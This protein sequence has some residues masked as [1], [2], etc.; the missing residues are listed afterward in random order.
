MSHDLVL[1]D[2]PPLAWRRRPAAL[3]AVAAARLLATRSPHRITRVLTRVRTGATPA[4]ADQTLAARN[5]VVA[6]SRHCA[7]DSSCL[8]RSLATALLCR[9]RG[10]WPTWHTGVRTRP[11]GAHAWVEA[12]GAPIG[13]RHPA[14]YYT[15]ILTV[16]PAPT[17]GTRP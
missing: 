6:V 2:R 14:D 3:L 8:Q 15:P 16:P 11:F 12:D 4:T 5:A 17:T 13:E 7:T 9:L 10:T 1:A